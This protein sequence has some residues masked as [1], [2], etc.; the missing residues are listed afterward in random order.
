MVFS[1]SFFYR[2]KSCKRI[3]HVESISKLTF[4]LAR[5]TS[6][7]LWQCRFRTRAGVLKRHRRTY[8]SFRFCRLALLSLGLPLAAAAFFCAF[9]RSVSRWLP[10]TMLHIFSTMQDH[11]LEALT[12][13]REVA[14]HKS[15]SMQLMSIQ[16][17]VKGRW[18]MCAARKI[19]SH[20]FVTECHT[21]MEGCDN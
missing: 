9:A 18:V 19:D 10:P 14:S 13:H 20:A 8:C 5:K 16:I 6:A 15:K 2:T 12:S 1:S 3:Q 11:H 17:Q 21:A 4:C 7:S